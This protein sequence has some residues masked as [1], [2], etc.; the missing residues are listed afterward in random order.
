MTNLNREGWVVGVPACFAASVLA[1][2]LAPLLLPADYSW[3]AHTTSEAAA[4][5]TEGAWL[6][7][8]GFLA[9]GLGVIWL[10]TRVGGRWGRWG[11]GFHSSFGVFMVAAAVFSARSWNPATPFDRTEDLLHSVAATAM[12]FAFAFG[13]LAV[14][15]RRRGRGG[16]VHGVDLVAIAASIVIPLAMTAWGE[17]AGLLQRGMFG[18]AYLWYGRE[19]LLGV[20]P[21]GGGTPS[22]AGATPWRKI[23]LA[24]KLTTFQ[25]HWQP[26]TVGEF[27]G[28]DL[29][30]VKVKGE[31]IWHSHPDTDDFFMVLEGRITLRMRDGSVT[32]G[33][34]EIFVVPRGVE[35][36]PLAEEEA[37]ILLI[38]PSGTPNTGDH[39]T[40]AP[41][42]VI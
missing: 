2:A 3:I 1:L 29:M 12:G 35:H 40:A 4:Q 25:E 28:H 33:P 31:F 27:N 17:G 18:I 5:G 30:V 26:R 36:S 9:F 34:G 24:E 10:T 11:V 6:A 22:P 37:H 21:E 39:R 16:G 7:R 23:N 32:L 41:R 14:L 42:R 8:L 13:V 15:L 38:E 19:A 20:R